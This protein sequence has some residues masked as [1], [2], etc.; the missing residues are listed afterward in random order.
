M[1]RVITFSTKFQTNHPKKGEPTYFVEK[2]Y[3]SLFHKNNLMEYPKGIEINDSI[4]EV[5]GHT[6]R[7][8]NRWKEGQYFSPR[9]WSEKPYMSP[10]IIIAPDTKIL[11]V[12][13]FKFFI[14]E[15]LRRVMFSIN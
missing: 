13:E 7:S 14:D 3:N 1:S 4:L 10:Q 5:K 8:G 15:K 2:F 6:I 11:K 9:I 12:Y